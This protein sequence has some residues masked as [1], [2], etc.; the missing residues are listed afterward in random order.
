MREDCLGF[1][2]T[3]TIMLTRMEIDI[4]RENST[5]RAGQQPKKRKKQI[6]ESCGSR[7]IHQVGDC[8]RAW[9]QWRLNNSSAP[10]N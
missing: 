7:E 4:I 1:K 9:P 3:K 2:S 6:K 10:F 8:Q 5:W